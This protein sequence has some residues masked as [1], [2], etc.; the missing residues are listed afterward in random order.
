MGEAARGT[1][2]RRY[3]WGNDGDSVKSRVRKGEVTAGADGTEP[4][5]R[6]ASSSPYGV[7]D[8]IGSVSQWVKI[9]TR[10]ISTRHLPPAIHRDR[11]VALSACCGA[12]N[13]MKNR[14]IFRPAIEG[15]ITR[16]T[17]S[18]PRRA[19]RGRRA[20]IFY[21]PSC[22]SHPRLSYDAG[23]HCPADISCDMCCVVSI[24]N[25]RR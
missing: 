21:S 8:L 6:Q 17:G 12:G 7:F 4:V 25:S 5:G 19:L 9:G 11:C 22:F 10:K 13:G 20:L 24:W 1:D 14:R 2:G 15:G 16:P 23:L 18:A 3:P